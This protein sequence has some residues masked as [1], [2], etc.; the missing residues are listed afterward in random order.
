MV[1]ILC[2]YEIV[3]L[4]CIGF[5]RMKAYILGSYVAIFMICNYG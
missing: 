1:L 2:L 3:S 5:E 4:N